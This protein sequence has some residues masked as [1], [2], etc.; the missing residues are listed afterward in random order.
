M[1]DTVP[2]T[3]KSLNL[4]VFSALACTNQQAVTI[5]TLHCSGTGIQFASYELPELGIAAA[6]LANVI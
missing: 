3:E 6:R 2:K 1:A 4:D 5:V